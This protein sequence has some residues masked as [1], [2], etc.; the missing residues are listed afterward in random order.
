MN[1]IRVLHLRAS[2]ELA[3]AEHVLLDICNRL[4]GEG[5]EFEVCLFSYNGKEAPLAVEVAVNRIPLHF[6]RMRFPPFYLEEMYRLA[7]LLRERKISILHCH[8]PRADVIGGLAAKLAGIPAISTVHGLSAYTTKM[9]MYEWVDL[10]ALRFLFRS[11]VSVSNKLREQLLDAGIAPEK[12]VVLRN[13]PRLKVNP[14]DMNRARSVGRIRLGYVGWL[15][16]EKGLAVLVEAF[17]NLR[18]THDVQLSI[19]G[20][21]PAKESV[22]RQ[23]ESL[24]LLD[25][26]TFH[27]Y[28]RDPEAIYSMMDL[29]I[30]PSLTEGIPLTLLEGMSFGLPIVASDVGG[31]PEV[32]QDNLSGLL[33]RPGRVDDLVEKMAALIRNPG[34]RARLG[35]GAR[36]RVSSICDIDKWKTTLLKVYHDVAKGENASFSACCRI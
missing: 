10:R 4:N 31:V 23:V 13:I 3:G 7:K 29:L 9:R 28:M 12:I 17:A 20:E 30:L 21:G 24:G 2:T 36:E 1:H 18:R 32:L 26:V 25:H 15:S 6:I 16:P 11:I 34:L 14:P 27:G 22:Q 35:G 5:I 8:G 33:T 19:I